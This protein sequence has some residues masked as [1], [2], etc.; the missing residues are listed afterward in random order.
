MA[1]IEEPIHELRRCSG[2]HT[3]RVC[4]FYRNAWFCING[5]TKCWRHRKVKWATLTQ[6]T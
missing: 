1:T 2:C 5:P 6:S 3:E 4:R